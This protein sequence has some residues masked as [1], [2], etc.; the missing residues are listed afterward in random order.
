MSYQFKRMPS[1]VG[2]LTLVARDGKLNAVLWEK[3]RA[4]RVRL[5]ELREANDSAVL[6]A[7]EQQLKEYFAGTRH[8]F[9]LELDFT[10]TAFQKQ[11][12]Q[13]LLTIPF[14]ET[15][16]YSQIAQQIGN[17][18]AVRA[19]GAANGRNP[20]SIIAPCHRVIGASGG[21]TG[22]AGG[23]EAKQYLLALEGAGQ[24]ELA[25]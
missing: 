1:P 7:A 18:K 11:V 19:V 24:A 17:P 12:W 13:A 8:Q 6:L 20:I 22:F 4:N 23:L 3:E 14:G 21:L 2:Q 15:R 16:S 10:G 5:G 9:E 25:F